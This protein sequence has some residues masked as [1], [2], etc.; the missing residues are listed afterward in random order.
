[1]KR[2]KSAG[3]AQ[4]FLAA[5]DQI[6]NLFI[7]AATTSPS[8]SIEPTG[9]RP[10]DLGRGHRCGRFGIAVR[11]PSPSRAYYLDHGGTS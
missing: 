3:Q 4:R 7:S 11:A 2:F 8:I 10:S 5:H 6:N 1:M 9:S